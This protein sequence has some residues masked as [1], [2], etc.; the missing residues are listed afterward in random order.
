MVLLATWSTR[1][2]ANAGD[3]NPMRKTAKARSQ[4]ARTRSI[5]RGGI[6][7]MI[8]TP[9]IA[10][11]SRCAERPVVTV[12]TSLIDGLRHEQRCKKA[13]RLGDAGDVRLEF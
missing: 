4:V 13:A 5:L 11:D 10:L 3:D 8:S 2:V 9:C 7:E 1:L 12:A 6:I